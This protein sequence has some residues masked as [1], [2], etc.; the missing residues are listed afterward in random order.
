M[1]CVANVCASAH[2]ELESESKMRAAVL[3]HLYSLSAKVKCNR[4]VKLLQVWHGMKATVLNNVL[5]SGFAA[6]AMLDDGFNL[7]FVLSF[8]ALADGTAR[9]SIF[10]PTQAMRR[11][12]L[13]PRSV[14]SCAVSAYSVC[15]YDS[16]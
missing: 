1:L 10:R 11:D 4:G 16:V 13:T 8:S 3:D 12:T 5:E 2:L 7:L 9:V 6:I 15:F 14:W